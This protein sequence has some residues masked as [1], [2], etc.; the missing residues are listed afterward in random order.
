MSRDDR[1]FALVGVVMFIL[2][3][4][5]LG[6]S[7]FSLSGYEAQFFQ[8]STDSAESFQAAAGGLDR[9]R[10]ALAKTSHLWSVKD[11]LPL[12]G[13]VY[14]VAR[15]EA[16]GDSVGDIRWSDPDYG[17]ILI[18][19]KAVKN[20]QTHFVEARYD[21]S[22]APSLYKRLM[23][24]SG[25]TGDSSSLAIWRQDPAETNDWNYWATWL[26]GEARVND[27]ANISHIFPFGFP[28][29]SASLTLKVGGVPIPEVDGFFADHW[30]GAEEARETGHNAYDLDA[31]S[32]PDSVKFFKTTR[33]GGDWSLDVPLTSPRWNDWDP[34]ITVHGTAV[35]LFDSGV[36]SEGTF[37]V[38]GSGHSNDMLVIVAKPSSDAGIYDPDPRAGHDFNAHR[39]LKA[40]AIALLGSISSTVPVILVGSGGV[41]LE[42]RDFGWA[43]TDPNQDRDDKTT[44]RVNCLSVFAPFAR[45][46]GPDND[47]GTNPNQSPSGPT[48]TLSRYDSDPA[49]SRID[50]LTDLGD[51]PNTAAGLKGK[52]RFLAGSW[53][54]VDETTP[55]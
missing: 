12:D 54:E 24:L 42:Q 5:I 22:R 35:W 40:S 37:Y 28:P 9:A 33:T 13:V 52:L 23:S 29:Q 48:L 32:S 44:T 21:P 8:H 43:G 18:R 41:L 20:G 16:D 14:A 45:V 17:D 47:M 6:L 30:D 53:R 36:R 4:T 38:S 39:S 7:L 49:N 25:A 1:G 26:F 50:R 19:V 31:I 2:V 34:R 51:L 10:F 3:L 11:H 15:R 46:L 55:P 27:D